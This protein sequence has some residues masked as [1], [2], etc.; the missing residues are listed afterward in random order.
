MRICFDIVI[1]TKKSVLFCAYLQRS[2]AAT[3]ATGGLP[4]KRTRMTLLQAHM[5]L[6]HS[7]MECT[8]ATAKYLG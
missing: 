1:K 7:N 2:K 3:Q 5:P 6:R 4:Q 8:K